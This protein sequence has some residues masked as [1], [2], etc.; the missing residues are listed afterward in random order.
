MRDTRQALPV[1]NIP[2]LALWVFLLRAQ[3]L[4]LHPGKVQLPKNQFGHGPCQDLYGITGTARIT[5]CDLGCRV[6]CH[7]I[8]LVLCNA[9][10]TGEV[11]EG[12]PEAVEGTSSHIALAHVHIKCA[13][14]DIAP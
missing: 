11:L 14:F 13:N 9:R 4:S 10:S 6:A 3:P 5:S 2:K 12:M 1:N 8:M 7:S